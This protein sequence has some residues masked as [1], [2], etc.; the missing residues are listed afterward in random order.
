MAEHSIRMPRGSSFASVSVA[1]GAEVVHWHVTVGFLEFC[2]A[3][4][5]LF[6]I[7]FVCGFSH[8]LI[9]WWKGENDEHELASW[10][11]PQVCILPEYILHAP[12]HQK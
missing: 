2:V 4:E 8:D 12:H 9:S 6:M 11:G 1:D 10:N 3:V 7:C 5:E